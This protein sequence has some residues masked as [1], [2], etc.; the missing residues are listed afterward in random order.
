MTDAVEIS[1]LSICPPAAALNRQWRDGKWMLAAHLSG[2]RHRPRLPLHRRIMAHG[3]RHWACRRLCSPVVI[4]LFLLHR[5]AVAG[6]DERERL[7]L[8]EPVAAA[9]SRESLLLI[10]LTYPGAQQG[11]DRFSAALP[12][13]I[14]FYRKNTRLKMKMAYAEF[15]PGDR[16]LD[17]ALFLYL[18]GYDAVLEFSDQEKRHLGAY[19]RTGG[20]LFADDVRP[21]RPGV[22]SWD[23]GTRDTPF[24]RQLKSLITDPLVLGEAGTL[25]R[26]IPKDHPLYHCYFDF[27]GGPPLTG[28]P[29]GNVVD[30]EM[31]EVRGRVVVIF[32]DLNLTWSWACP[33]ARYGPNSL[34]LGANLIVFATAQK[35]AG[36]PPKQP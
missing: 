15:G 32:S 16:R 25:W 33:E 27:P 18:T 20:L 17:Q 8:P 36:I 22:R 30:L 10:A 14:Q 11:R 7:Q 3:P 24:D 2:D 21:D 6:T 34:R 28:A 31:L 29:G 5:G 13:L 26:K 12:E 19:L 35:I 1:A 9:Q 23:V 4:A